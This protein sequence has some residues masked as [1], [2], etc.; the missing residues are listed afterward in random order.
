MSVKQ[1]FEKLDK[2]KQIGSIIPNV[3]H[4]LDAAH[5]MNIIISA[6]SNN[7][8]PVLTIHDCF[9]TT[10]NQL[11]NLT[12]IIKFEFIKLYSQEDFLQ[13]FYLRNKN[14]FLIDNKQKIFIDEMNKF[15]YVLIKRTKHYLPVVPKLGNLNLNNILKSKYIVN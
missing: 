13:T 10:P 3:I 9:G 12:D 1:Y 2:R 5:L 6:N 15:E 7:I 11:N 4:S 8:K 14:K